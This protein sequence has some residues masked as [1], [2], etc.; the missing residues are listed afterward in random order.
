[1]GDGQLEAWDLSAR[2]V[3]LDG[4]FQAEDPL[5]EE[6]PGVLLRYQDGG[7]FCGLANRRHPGDLDLVGVADECYD[8]GSLSIGLDPGRCRFWFHIYPGVGVG[9]RKFEA[10]DSYRRESEGEGL[11]AR[12]ALHLYGKVE[13]QIIDA[14]FRQQQAVFFPMR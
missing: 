1:M 11:D 10:G 13:L 12:R 8:P 4:G 9:D 6:G 3:V 2:Q 14:L 7:I 5:P